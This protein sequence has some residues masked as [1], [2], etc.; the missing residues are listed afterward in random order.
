[1]A[2]SKS[3]ASVGKPAARGASAKTLARQQRAALA[4]ARA[5]RQERVDAAQVA[6]FD[7]VRE[8][9][10]A[11]EALA[12]AQAKH[13]AAVQGAEAAKRDAVGRL[14]DEEQQPLDDVVVLL[15]GAGVVDESDLKRLR[16]EYRQAQQHTSTETV[17]DSAAVS[18]DAATDADS[19]GDAEAVA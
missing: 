4:A 16:T 5:E 1:M 19:G 15:G 6:W 18:S 3:G 11:D 9:E 2:G 13:T 17:R 14:L 12:A 7:G 8:V 10:R